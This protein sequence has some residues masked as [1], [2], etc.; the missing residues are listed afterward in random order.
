MNNLPIRFPGRRFQLWVY[1]VSH[2][3]LLLRSNKSDTQSH[4]CEV[5]FKNVAHVNVPTVIDNLEIELGTGALPA[6][7]GELGLGETL[8]CSVYL[9]KGD[10]CLGYVVAGHVGY[11]EDAGDYDS[12]SSL[13]DG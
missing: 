8:E 7:A 13:L 10:N 9:I 1:T 11:A 5:L 3:Q 12:A 4:R 6:G 2:R